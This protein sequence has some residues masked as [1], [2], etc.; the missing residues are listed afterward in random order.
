MCHWCDC[1][2][3]FRSHNF[4]V[5]SLTS[6]QMECMAVAAN[7]HLNMLQLC[8]TIPY[9]WWTPDAIIP[10]AKRNSIKMSSLNGC[11]VDFTNLF[12]AEEI[13]LG[14]GLPVNGQ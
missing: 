12:F 5:V 9:R 2:D 6:Q 11:A 8:C 13:K 7:Y 3:H 14:A 1:P 10:V 4:V